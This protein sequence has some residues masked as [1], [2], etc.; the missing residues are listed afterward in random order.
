[1]FCEPWQCGNIAHI[2]RGPLKD[3]QNE[4]YILFWIYFEL[5]LN[6]ISLVYIVL[7]KLNARCLGGMSVTNI[8]DLAF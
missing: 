6:I 8:S 2:H 3:L 4:I 7:K 5:Y 1:M